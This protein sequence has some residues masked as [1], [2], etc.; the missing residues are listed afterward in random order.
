MR[1]KAK[2]A[3]ET[4]RGDRVVDTKWS[5]V[6]TF[7]PPFSKAKVRAIAECAQ[8]ML[9]GDCR[10]LPVVICSDSQAALD[11]ALDGYLVRSREVLRCRGLLGE[12]A[13]ANSVSLLWAP[14]HSGVIGNEKAIG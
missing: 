3:L 2:K 6:S 5:A 7:T 8:A 13:R 12:L 10:G 1:P 9:E 14:G 4:R 11:G